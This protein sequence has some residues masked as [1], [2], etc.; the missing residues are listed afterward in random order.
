MCIYMNHVTLN[1]PLLLQNGCI[2][3]SFLRYN[4][5]IHSD[6]VRIDVMPLK[7][8]ETIFAKISCFLIDKCGSIYNN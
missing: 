8:I 6:Y 5:I 2:N 7:P 4:F 3:Q 1:W